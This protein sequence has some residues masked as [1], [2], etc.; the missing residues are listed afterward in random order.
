MYAFQVP[1]G[2]FG[3]CVC[4]YRRTFNSLASIKER[5]VQ[6]NCCSVFSWADLRLYVSLTLFNPRLLQLCHRRSQGFQWEE[7]CKTTLLYHSTT[8]EDCLCH[9]QTSY[10]LLS[11]LQW[12]PIFVLCLVC[13][14]SPPLVLYQP[15][16]ASHWML[17]SLSLNPPSPPPLHDLPPSIRLTTH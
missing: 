7:N 10:I 3:V 9:V 12:M 8:H 6:G 15:H 5:C 2:T 11:S 16:T 17:T 4:A 1:R 13:P 14:P